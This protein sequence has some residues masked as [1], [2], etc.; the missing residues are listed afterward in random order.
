MI[1]NRKRKRRLD[2]FI[3]NEGNE[4]SDLKHKEK[5][6]DD[7]II[8]EQK[9]IILKRFIFELRETLSGNE[10]T[11]IDVLLEVAKES[12]GINISEIGRILTMPADKAHNTWRRIKIKAMDHDA[13]KR[14]LEDISTASPIGDF[15]IDVIP[16][17][18]LDLARKCLANLAL[19]DITLLSTI[20]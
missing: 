19:S 12:D 15:S 10:K 5:L 1:N 14:A 17:E 8:E 6:I 16:G 4:K 13:K 7:V 9:H 11:F 3:D 18:S 20:L 2:R